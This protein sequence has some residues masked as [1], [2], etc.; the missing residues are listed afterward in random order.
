MQTR[1]PN[2]LKKYNYSQE[3]VCFVTACTQD[4]IH[5]FGGIINDHVDLN[6]FGKIVEM[7]WYDLPKHNNNCKLD[8]FIIMPNHVHGIIQIVG[9][10]SK[11]VRGH[12]SNPVRN[13]ECRF[14]NKQK[15]NDKKAGNGYY[16][17]AGLE[18]AP[19]VS[20]II[21]QF[22]TF[23]A[24]RINQKRNTLGKKI[25][26]RSFH[27]HIIRDENTLNKIRQYIINP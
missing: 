22:K 4:K 18:S 2:R 26:Q 11:P 3:G 12:D 14:I 25:W 24:K 10:V 27:D 9:T 16:Q 17:R 6:E 23:S 13:G 20:E 21:R 15:N 8:K 7:T 19:T 1:K 5:L